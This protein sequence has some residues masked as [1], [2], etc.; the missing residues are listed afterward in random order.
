MALGPALNQQA[1][2]YHTLPRVGFVQGQSLAP[3]Y[4]CCM[5]SHML[6]PQEPLFGRQATFGFGF[7]G[8]LLWICPNK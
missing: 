3:S 5:L 7:R 1:W 2:G 8:R 4:D 6:A